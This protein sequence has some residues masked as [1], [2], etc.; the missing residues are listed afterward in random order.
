MTNSESIHGL[1][2][3]ALEEIRGILKPYATSIESVGVFGSRATG[4]MRPDSDID[5][6]IHGSIDQK[7]VDRLWTIFS[8]STLAWPVD[9]VAYNHVTYEPFKQHIN[10]VA[11]PLF[12]HEDLLPPERL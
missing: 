4:R 5:L 3:H 8:E 1:P 9:I 12:T 10:A 2:E 7:T 11:I 6:V